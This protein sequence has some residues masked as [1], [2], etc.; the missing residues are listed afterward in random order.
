MTLPDAPIAYDVA[1]TGD[2][3]PSLVLRVD[4]VRWEERPTLYHAGPTQSF[5]TELAANGGV[6]V[7]F[8]DKDGRRPATGRG[9]VTATYRVGGG[10]VGELPS[11]AIDSLI[12]SIR[13]VQ[14]VFGAGPT[15][16]GADQD[17]E[18]RIRMLAP[19]RARAFGRVVSREDLVDLALAYPG[20]SHAT[21]WIGAG[22]SGCDCS[23]TGVHLAFVRLSST[24]VRPPTPDEVGSLTRYLSALRDE[25]VLICV[26]AATV[27]TLNLEASLVLSSERLPSAVF[28]MVRAKMTD[29]E[30]PLVAANRTLGQ[31]LDS[32]DVIAVIHEV[33]DVLGVTSIQA[34][35]SVLGRLAAARHQLLVIHPEPALVLAV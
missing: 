31:P 18:R 23:S 27:T 35:N 7:I 6:A 17:D 26:C 28:G 32:S 3:V 2:L 34:N 21:A 25:T 4:G 19:T 22:P 33:P 15:S 16:G 30:S 29:E 10:T 24:G 8:G 13:G 11:G 20:V 9:N 12:G 5:A 1:D 14:R